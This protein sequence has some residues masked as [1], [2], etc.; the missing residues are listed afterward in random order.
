M[1]SMANYT[2]LIVRNV[3][4]LK[5]QT[6]DFLQVEDPHRASNVSTSITLINPWNFQTLSYLSAKTHIK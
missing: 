3:G 4:W 6:L 2:L 5:L 1:Q